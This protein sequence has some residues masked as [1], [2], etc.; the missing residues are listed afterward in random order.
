[1]FGHLQRLPASYF[2]RTPLGDAIS[3]CTA[4]V[5]TLDTMFTSGVATLVANLFRLVTI[6]AAMIV[7]SPL[8]TLVAAIALPPL[9]LITRFFQVRI[10][11]AERATRKAV[12]EMNIHLQETLRG[13]EV[14]QTFNRDAAFVDR[15]RQ[16]L[17][18]LLR[19]ANRS[20]AWSAF[21]P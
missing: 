13:V 2:D 19:A 3:R 5:D 12:G 11:D 4:D 18:R 21:Y 7:L 16:V 1:L 6:A 14:I 8:L 17:Q 20:T 15:F 10:R 9:V